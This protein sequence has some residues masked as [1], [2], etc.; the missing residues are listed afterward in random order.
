MQIL[1]KN[2]KNYRKDNL[3][4]NKINHNFIKKNLR[5]EKFRKLLFRIVIRSFF[6]I[7]KKLFSLL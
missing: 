3:K 7:V 1:E 4:R 2:N 6:S 5:I